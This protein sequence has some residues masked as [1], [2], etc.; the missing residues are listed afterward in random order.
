MHPVLFKLPFFG[1]I[2]V[3]SYGVLVA[4]AFL[5][6]IFWVGYDAKR[7][8][9]DAKRA[10]DLVFYII[11]AGILGSRILYIV[12]TEWEPFLKNPIIFFK[13]WEGG[14]VWYGG[15]IAAL[16]VA[17]I[18]VRHYRLPVL[19]YLDCFAPAVALGH[20]IGR[21]G[22][23]MAGCC[24][25]KPI[26]HDAWYAMIFPADVGSFAPPGVALYPTQLMEATAELITFCLLLVV[27]HY[28]KFNGQVIASYLILYGV[29]R[30]VIEFFRGDMDRGFVIPDLISV[31]QLVSIVMILLGM[32]M[33]VKLFKR[34][35]NI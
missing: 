13:M 25:G 14:L 17:V 3:Y 30:F 16:I 24:F 15:L 28:K 2:P 8:G 32:A 6:A 33:Y 9:L 12:I 29:A 11:L 4:I 18:Y 34:S 10:T 35:T 26:G 7:S 22:C 5:V 21:L 27:R 23:T 19:P 31:S 1:G 20:A